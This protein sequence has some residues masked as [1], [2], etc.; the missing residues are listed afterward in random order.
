MTK[1]LVALYEE[2]QKPTSALEFLK[3]HLGAF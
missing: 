3:D 2:T 1:E